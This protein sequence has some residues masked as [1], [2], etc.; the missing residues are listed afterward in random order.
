MDPDRPLD[1][2]RT[3]WTATHEFSHL[4]LPYVSR[5]DRWLSE[6]LA[7]YYQNVL[8]ARD[9]RL[10]ETDAWRKLDAKRVEW[11]QH[12]LMVPE[13]KSENCKFKNPNLSAALSLTI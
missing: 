6:G 13:V 7:S 1:D 8:R 11:L 12:Q 4:L 3:D 5:R 2:L 9:G 10:S